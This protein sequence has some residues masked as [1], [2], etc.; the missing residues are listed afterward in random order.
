MKLEYKFFNSFF[1]PYVVSVTLCTLLVSIFLG[2]YTNTYYDDRTRNN[3]INIEKMYS[4]ININSANVLLTTTFQKIQSGLNEHILFY[5]KMANKLIK[6][7]ENHKLNGDLMKCL[8]SLN[9]FHCIFIYGDPA[10]MA[11]WIQE[12]DINEYNVNTNKN[13]NLELISFSNILQN[14]DANIEATTPNIIYYFFY[15]EKTELYTAYPLKNLCSSGQF[16]TLKL[17]YIANRKQCIDDNGD[18]Y[19]VYKFKCELFYQNFLKSKSKLFDN[20]YSDER[21]KTIFVTNFYNDYDYRKKF[22]MCIEFDDPITNGKGYSCAQVHSDDIISSLENIN[23]NMIGYFFVSIVGFNNVFFFSQGPANPKTLT[24]SIFDWQI[25]YNLDEKANFYRNHKKI[26]SSNYIEYISNSLNEEIFVNGKNAQMQFF[27]INGKK[28]KYS[29]YPVVLENLYGEKEHVFSIIYVYEDELFLKEIEPYTSSII[30]KILLEILFFVIFG[31]SLLYLIYLTF[32]YLT[33]YIAIPIKNVNY[34]LK[35]INIGGK[36]RLEYID[37]LQKKQE[38]NV[39]GLEN[40]Y[41][42]ENQNININNEFNEQ[43]NNNLENKIELYNQEKDNLIT[44]NNSKEQKKEDK[45]KYSELNK[46]YDEESEY[47]EKEFNFNDFDEQLLKYRPLE[48]D[49]LVNSLIDLKNAVIFTSRDRQLEQIIKYSQSEDIFRNYKNKK[50]EIICQSNLGNLQSQLLKYDKAIYHL[51]ISLQDNQLKRFLN[52]NLSDELDESDILLRVISNS[53]NISKIEEKNNILMEKQKNNS[54]EYFSQTFIGILI[55]TR[56]VKL[57]HAYYMFFKTFKKLQKSK[58]GN[59]NGLFMNTSFHTINYYHK[60]LIQFIY[61][62]YFKNDLIKIGESILDYIEFLIKFKLKTISNDED[63]LDIQNK[64]KSEYQSKLNFKKQVFKKVINWFNLFEDYIN[65]VKN[66]STLADDKTIIDNYSNDN[67]LNLEGQSSIMFRVNMQKGDFLKGKFSL[68]CKNFNDSLYYFIRAA[69]KKRIVIDGLIKKRSLKNIFKILLRMEKKFEEF[70]FK[71]SCMDIEMKEYQKDKFNLLLKTMSN[72]KKI[73]NRISKSKHLDS[74]TFAD[75]IKKIKRIILNEI[76]ESSKKEEKDIL[77]LIDLNI[78]NTKQF[79]NLYDKTYNIDSFIEQTKLILNE[80]LSSSDGFG[81][82]IYF[83]DYEIVCPLK[84]VNQI[85][86]NSFSKDLLNYRNK[87]DIETDKFNVIPDDFKLD[88]FELN[89]LENEDENSIEESSDITEKIEDNKEKI[90]GLVKS[91][92]YLIN[93][94]KMKVNIKKDIYFIFFTD[95]INNLVMDIKEME[96]I[97][98][99]LNGD[100]QSIFLLVGKNK[101]INYT[102]DKILIENAKRFEELVLSGFSEKSEVVEFE[103]MRKIKT[104][105]SN[106]NVIKDEIIYPNEIYK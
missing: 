34:M 94:K 49:N 105:L 21:N 50:G 1:Y 98:L 85:D 11:V 77:I 95:I 106:N 18:Y 51:A 42:D 22:T 43:I 38:E 75:K 23:E 14:M 53:F 25:E 76:G 16:Y 67:E 66:N 70:G 7:E 60:I 73:T 3:I 86:K 33:K 56:Y 48:I 101:R 82:L 96:E 69:K 54:N 81:V 65:Y 61:L 35:G 80:Y 88:D 31:C 103:N 17:S 71:Y 9:F 62:S 84:E 6:S 13:V 72:G 52:K 40:F 45:K 87:I 27:F 37:F 102:N 58:V 104:I 29:I 79:D 5:Q 32:Y 12:D 47:I 97:F 26:F 20:N 63:F 8:L 36:K 78:Y 92:N 83:N 100:K 39:E 93:Y 59:V 41:L 91:I 46:K 64:D 10:K 89:S 4:K 2:Y 55:N 57:I 24:E 15:F 44:K 90:R 19:S 30:I 68:L 99:N 74:T 28:Y